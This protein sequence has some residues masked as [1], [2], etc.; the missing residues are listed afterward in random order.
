MEE[1][2]RNDPLEDREECGESPGPALA[3]ELMN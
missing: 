2:K 1:G 3:T